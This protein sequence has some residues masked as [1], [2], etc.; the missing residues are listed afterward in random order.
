MQNENTNQE[1]KALTNTFVQNCFVIFFTHYYPNLGELSIRHLAELAEKQ[2]H[3]G[4]ETQAAVQAFVHQFFQFVR[5]ATTEQFQAMLNR[6]S[7]F[8]RAI[9]YTVGDVEENP[10]MVACWLNFLTNPEEPQKL[11]NRFLRKQ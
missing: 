4:P 8:H 9:F 1:L 10:H 3:E 5:P 6:V 11:F 7:E 2:R